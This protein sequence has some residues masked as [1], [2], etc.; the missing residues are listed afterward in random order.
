MIPENAEAYAIKGLVKGLLEDDLASAKTDLGKAILLNASLAR[1]YMWKF[2]ILHQES[3]F[4]EAWNLLERAFELDPLSIENQLNRGFY[5]SQLGRY[6]ESQQ[7]YR[8]TIN[9]YPTSPMGFSGLA[10][11]YYLTGDIS[12]SI[13]NWQTA[14]KLSPDNSHIAINYIETLTQDGVCR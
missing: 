5:L 2:L 7:Q 4:L 6:E 12:A 8:D 10:S 9:D 3:E 14:M 11:L 13:Q 1:A